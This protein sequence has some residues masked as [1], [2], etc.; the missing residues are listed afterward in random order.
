MLLEG[1]KSPVIEADVKQVEST[2]GLCHFFLSLLIC[3]MTYEDGLA[4]LSDP[5]KLK[6]LC[7]DFS[8]NLKKNMRKEAGWNIFSKLHLFKQYMAHHLES[9]P[10]YEFTQENKSS[11][12]PS[13]NDWKNSIFI[14]F[15]KLG[16]TQSEI[17][18]MNIKKLFME[19]T[20]WAESEGQ[21]KVSNRYEAEQLKQFKKKV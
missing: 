21:I 5:E 19:W 10:Y 15:K 12:T 2:E 17:L 14:I 13:G 7:S 20:G 16:Y 9:M 1:L 18:N 6:S 8:R 3:S 4:V 11:G